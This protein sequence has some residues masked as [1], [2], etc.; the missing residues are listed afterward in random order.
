MRI[1]LLII[2]LAGFTAGPLWA[3]TY[4]CRDSSGQTH[5]SDSLQGLSEECR[6]QGEVV[7]S[8]NIG[9]L[10]FVPGP[11]VESSDVKF[12]RSVQ[13]AEQEEQQK[14]NLAS[15]LRNSAENLLDRYQQ[16]I[17][18]R[19]QARFK[20]NYRKRIR[21]IEARRKIDQIVEEKQQLLTDLDAARV[22]TADKEAVRKILA[23]IVDE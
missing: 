1:L 5:F 17:A 15:Q 2:V 13:A 16:A 3:N 19:R 7:E 11:Q 8:G 18:E 22:P 23:G 20:Y 9:N 4:S 10:N 12:K 6:D 14:R 21:I